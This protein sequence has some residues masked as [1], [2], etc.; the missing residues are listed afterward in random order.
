[1]SDLMVIR[2]FERNR[3]SI[4]V[5]MYSMYLYFLLGLSLRN[6]SKALEPFK[7]EKRSHVAI[8]GWIQQFGSSNVYN[9]RRRIVAFII[10]ETMIQT[11]SHHFWLRICIEPIHKSVLGIHISEQRNTFV[12]EKFIR[13]LVDKYDKHTVYTDSGI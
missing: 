6:T 1:M 5:V 9:K 2:L 12:A 4:I 13:S 3:T 8:W 7:D 10:D 11:G